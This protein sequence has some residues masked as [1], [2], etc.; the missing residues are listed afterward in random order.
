MIVLDRHH[1]RAAFRQMRHN[2]KLTQRQ[3][4]ERLRAHPRTIGYR[5]SGQNHFDFD[6]IQQTAR[7]FGYD[8]ALVPQ[9]HPG[10]RPTG[11]GWPA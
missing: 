1:L 2:R 5:E 9:R 11:T 4:A 7:A 6:A 10:A 8:V 3:L